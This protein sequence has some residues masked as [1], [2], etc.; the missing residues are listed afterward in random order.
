MPSA[1]RLPIIRPA[2]V[3]DIPA[4]RAQLI[5]TW[6]ATYDTIYGPE[7]VRE[8]T[9]RWHSLVALAEQVDA[10][11]SAFLLADDADRI[12]ASSYAQADGNGMAVQLFRLYV[13]PSDQHRGLGRRLMAETFARFPGAR[14]HRLEVEPRNAKAIRFYEREG[15]TQVDVIADIG[16][17][18]GGVAALVYERR[19]RR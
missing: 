19:A 9:T 1:T 4:V 11:R 12:V 8:I 10:E 15:F 16:R 17:T 14:R 5:E 18:D 2:V 6:H 3:A 7:L 13:H